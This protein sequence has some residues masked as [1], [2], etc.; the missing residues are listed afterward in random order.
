MGYDVSFRGSFKVSP[1][2]AAKH[3]ATIRKQM[4][5]NDR[6]DWILS[7]DGTKVGW[8]GYEKFNDYLNQLNFTINLFKPLG[9]K[10][11]GMVA[12]EGEERGDYGRI[13]VE[14]NRVTTIEATTY[15]II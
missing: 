10:L 8:N 15:D 1:D 9:Y 14:D 13:V 5:A 2:M 6:C 12:W 4:K 11:N 7:V 3:V